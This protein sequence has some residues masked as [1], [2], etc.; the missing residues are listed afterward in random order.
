M[1]AI[2][3]D[4]LAA[5]VTV[6]FSAGNGHRAFPAC[7][8]DVIAVGGTT[9]DSNGALKASSYAS[10]FAS[11]LFP[12][13]R[14]PDFCGVVGESGNPPL[15]GHI[16]LPVPVGSK[17]DGDNL[18]QGARGRGW[19]IFSGTSASAPQVAGIAARMLS[20]NPSLS[21]AGIRAIL[22]ATARDVENGSSAHGEEAGPGMDLATGAGFVDA[23]AACQRV[24]QSSAEPQ[25][26]SRS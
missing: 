3:S 2:L 17:R 1:S 14:V 25:S 24:R 9:V 11:N 13:R 19:G 23:F 16:L 6:I 20:V 26:A 18:P 21:P 4:A 8:P 7:H 22:A 15:P 10:S 12:G 5:G